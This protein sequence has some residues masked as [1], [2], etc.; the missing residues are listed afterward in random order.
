MLILHVEVGNGEG[1]EVWYGKVASGDT[2]LYDTDLFTKSGLS[3]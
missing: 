2:L 3:F 1:E